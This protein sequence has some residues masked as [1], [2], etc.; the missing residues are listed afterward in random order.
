M[1]E[2]ET[3]GVQRQAKSFVSE[4]QNFVSEYLEVGKVYSM[5]SDMHTGENC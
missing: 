4:Y 3:V 1:S 2:R 5:P